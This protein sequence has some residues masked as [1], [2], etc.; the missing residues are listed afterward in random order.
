MD[1]QSYRVVD[2]HIIMPALGV[3]AL[4]IL[5]RHVYCAYRLEL[6]LK[7]EAMALWKSLGRP[8][9]IA[10]FYSDLQQFR[11]KNKEAIDNNAVLHHSL[12]RFE[13]SWKYGMPL[14]LV[15]TMMVG[16]LQRLFLV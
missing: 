14:V 10:Y 1:L 4:L 12:A 11:S 13:R 6:T 8:K 9:P 16:F 5:A 2:M 7:R 3:L 15:L